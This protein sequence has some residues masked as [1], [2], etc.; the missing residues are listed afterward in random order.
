MNIRKIFLLLILAAFMVVLFENTEIAAQEIPFNYKRDELLSI[1]EKS[2]VMRG[3]IKIVDLAYASPKGGK[4]SAYL[5][6]PSKIAEGKHPGVIFQ[7]WMMPEKANANRTE[8]L[9]EA[10]EL[11][12]KIGAVSLLVE[13]P[14]KRQGFSPPADKPMGTADI[15]IITQAIIDLRRGADLLL[16]RKEIDKNHLFYVG[17]SFGASMGGILLG[18]EP[19]IKAFALMA[20]EF[21]VV[22]RNR[23]NQSENFVKWRGKFKKD[24]F[25]DYLHRIS[26]VDPANQVVKPRVAPVLLQYAK[27]DEF[28]T[29]QQD[30]IRAAHLVSEPKILKIYD[31][32]GHELNSEARRDRAEWLMNQMNGKKADGQ[33][34]EEPQQQKS[35]ADYVNPPIVYSVPRMNEVKI[36]K[37]LTYK[38]DG[39]L[40]LK[41]DVFQSP[42]LKVGERRPVVFF[43]HGGTPLENRPKDWGIFQSWGK[44]VAASGMTAV[45]FN[46]QNDFVLGESDMF[47]ALE[48]TRKNA[49]DLGVDENRIAIVAY[50]AGGPLL[51]GVLRQKPA[52]VKALGSFYSLLDTAEWKSQ[53]K[54]MSE[55]KLRHYSVLLNLK[56]CAP[57]IFVASAG[58]DFPEFKTATARFIAEALKQNTAI[59]LLNHPTG[60]H[61][62]DNQNNDA[63]SKEIIRRFIEFLQRNLLADSQ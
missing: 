17:H 10:I 48:Y 30:I 56:P 37:D 35:L 31:K 49:A 36:I 55:E 45:I 5:I 18:V 22:E 11:A 26:I 34:Q 40:E 60:V 59:E 14:M 8:F 15:A 21:A 6:V 12:E 19:R 24:E 1:Q 62:F 2:T 63:R 33:K 28:L 61:G 58:R 52:Y 3:A 50:S 51:S 42:D 39:E 29:G 47:T 57:P 20:G 23:N 25:E 13:A 43:I 44:L 46:H 54:G 9:D 4:V 41:L 32:G 27:D 16:T 38:K 53:A 7:H